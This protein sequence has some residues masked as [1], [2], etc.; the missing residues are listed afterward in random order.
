MADYSILVTSSPYSGTQHQLA[1]RFAYTATRCGHSIKRVFLYQDAVLA[2]SSLQQPPQGQTSIANDWADFSATCNTPV[3]ACIANSLR[4]GVIN[5]VE[6]KRY[7]LLSSNL[8]AA[9]ELCGLGEMTE[10]LNDSHKV[11]QF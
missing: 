5:D 10:A 3:H 8:H 9:I 1:L 11:I 4:R 2:A 7:D 6:S